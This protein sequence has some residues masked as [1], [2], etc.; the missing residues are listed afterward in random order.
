MAGSLR[1]AIQADAN[2]RREKAER[3]A[4]ATPA[5]A[6]HKESDGWR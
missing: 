2:R 1:S 4:A 6:P 3:K 5:Q